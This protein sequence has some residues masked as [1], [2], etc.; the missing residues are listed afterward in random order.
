M[1]LTVEGKLITLPD[2]AIELDQDSLTATAGVATPI[3]VT[4]TND[5]SSAATSSSVNGSFGEPIMQLEIV[6]I[7]GCTI[8]LT[9][10]SFACPLGNLAVGEVVEFEVQVVVASAGTYT[11]PMAVSTPLDELLVGNNDGRS[12]IEM[13]AGTT[14]LST[15][16]VPSK[17]VV[18][19]GRDVRLRATLRNVGSATAGAPELCVRTPP[20]MSI[21]RSGG[22]SL[23]RGRLCWSWSRLVP[24][25][26]ATVTYVLRAS[27]VVPDGA[28][29]APASAGNA[30][31]ASIV[32]AANSIR[33]IGGSGREAVTG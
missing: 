32:T 25:R 11:L 23:R 28:R 26:S 2:L 30:S 20:G 18:R 17:R 8:T 9:N 16:I 33:I 1:V 12:T 24:G 5:G 7:N 21:V 6:G 13:L 22:G 4:V 19:A 14:A 10:G 31:N 29:R 27:R 15:T 3:G